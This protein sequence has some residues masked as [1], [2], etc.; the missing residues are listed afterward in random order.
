MSMVRSPKSISGAVGA[1]LGNA[2]YKI[3]VLLR[4]AFG[5]ALSRITTPLDRIS[6]IAYDQCILVGSGV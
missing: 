4:S 3:G 5:I 6:Q 2:P 1:T